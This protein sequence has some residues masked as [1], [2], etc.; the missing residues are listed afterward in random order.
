ML[1]K[2]ADPRYPQEREPR[3]RSTGPVGLKM[4]SRPPFTFEEAP[5]LPGSDRLSRF[6]L[7]LMRRVLHRFWDFEVQGA[8][9]IPLTGGAVITPN[10]LSF[11]DSL[12][13]PAALPRRVWAIGKGEYMDSWKTKHLFSA[14]GM[15]PIDRSG[16]KAAMDALDTA[17]AV[18]DTGKLFMLYPEGTRSRSGNLHKGRTGAAR[19]ALRCD[20]PIVPVGHEGTIDVQPPDTFA[21]KPGKLVIVRIGKPIHPRDFGSINNPTLA[22]NL[23]DAVMY[24]ISQLSGQRYVNTYAGKGDA[25]TTGT[26]PEPRRAVITSQPMVIDEVDATTTG[27]SA[28]A[29]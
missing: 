25:G 20:V 19:L 13:V 9:N 18:I 12:F 2:P 14:M 27:I 8:D 5:D 16:G 15:I 10:H 6:G 22:R 28:P 1:D 4:P 11:C 29:G 7:G 3:R 24:E 23:T 26:T 21:L 17:A